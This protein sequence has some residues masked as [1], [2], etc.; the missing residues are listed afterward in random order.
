[1][2]KKYIGNLVSMSPAMPTT[3]P[4]CDTLSKVNRWLFLVFFKEK[5]YVKKKSEPFNV[6]M[7]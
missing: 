2:A 7:H 6:C 5:K 1:M 4:Q 3:P